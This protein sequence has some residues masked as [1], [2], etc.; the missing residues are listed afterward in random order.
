MV[1]VVAGAAPIFVVV[2]H[3]FVVVVA[4]VAVVMFFAAMMPLLL[5]LTLPLLL[6]TPPVPL[7][8]LQVESIF[9]DREKLHKS[10]DVEALLLRYQVVQRSMDKNSANLT[11]EWHIDDQMTRVLEEYDGLPSNEIDDVKKL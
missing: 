7:P 3:S 5:P 2:A 8:L 10:H 6:L 4:V 9:A 11:D 1:L